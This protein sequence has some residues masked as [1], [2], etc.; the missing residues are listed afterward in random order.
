MA[1]TLEST[2]FNQGDLIPY[3]YTCDGDDISPPLAWSNPPTNTQS[4]VLI[5]DDPDA[6]VGT[7]DHWL[8]FNIPA[9]IS[10]LEENNRTLPA[11]ACHGKNSWN[12]NDYGGPCPPDRIHRYFFRLYA[13]DAQLDLTEGATKKQVLDA[14]Q[15]HVLANAE[16]M[17]KYDRNRE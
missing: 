13:L 12:R 8:I 1:F 5:M 9:N 11:G 6:P 7:W 2:A 4:Y 3:I 17:G 16:L 10:H 15:G 14:M